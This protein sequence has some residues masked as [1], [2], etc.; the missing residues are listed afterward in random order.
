MTTEHD[1]IH[2]Q[3]LIERLRL[4]VAALEQRVRDKDELVEEIK[5][6]RDKFENHLIKLTEFLEIKY[7]ADDT[8]AESRNSFLLKKA[9]EIISAQKGSEFYEEAVIKKIRDEVL[10]VIPLTSYDPTSTNSDLPNDEIDFYTNIYTNNNEA[11][12]SYKNTEPEKEIRKPIMEVLTS[13][14]QTDEQENFAEHSSYLNNPV[15]SDN[16]FQKTIERIKTSKQKPQ[17]TNNIELN[18]DDKITEQKSDLLDKSISK[19]LG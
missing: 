8:K 12:S 14:P 6:Q 16:P 19:N 3:E 7:K 18:G 1:Q 2:P 11:L 13:S 9:A 4:K 5:S 15:A 17:D 10:D